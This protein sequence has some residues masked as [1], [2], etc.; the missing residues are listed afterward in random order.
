MG[1]GNATPPK[2]LHN[3]SLLIKYSNLNMLVDCGPTIP[4]QLKKFGLKEIDYL[5]LTHMHGDHFVGVAFILLERFL[6]KTKQKLKIYGPSGDLVKHLQN[7]FNLLFLDLKDKI[8]LTDLA[9]FHEL[10][11]GDEITLP[12]LTIKT[13]DSRHSGVLNTL[14]YLFTLGDKK[15]LITGDAGQDFP[16]EKHVRE[17]DACF[18]DCNSYLTTTL[19]HFSHEALLQR[20][21]K[22]DHH[23]I[24]LYH[25][26]DTILNNKL[27]FVLPS[28]LEE[29]KL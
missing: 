10:S 20:I 19:N 5:F 26:G 16:L 2:G 6:K 8:K 14:S 4:Y 21:P 18:V 27:S 22:K 28:E 13:F 15:V 17:V 1:I 11:P 29:I 24:F 3:A 25:V 12:H 7:T 9:E 23:K